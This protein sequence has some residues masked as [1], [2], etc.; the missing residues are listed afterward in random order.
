[1][2]STT[3]SATTRAIRWCKEFWAEFDYAQRRALEIR[4]GVPLGARGES[5]RERALIEEL[6][7]LYAYEAPD[8][9]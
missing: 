2:T 3:D 9:D 1:M 5:L 6:E 8:S 7:A 4:L